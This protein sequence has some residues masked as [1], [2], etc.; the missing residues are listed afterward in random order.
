[1]YGAEPGG[2]AGTAVRA[3]EPRRAVAVTGAVAVA[4]AVAGAVAGIAAGAESS[5]PPGP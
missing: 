3:G 1:M 2:P 5:R 4:K